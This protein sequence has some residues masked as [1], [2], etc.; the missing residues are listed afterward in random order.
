MQQPFKSN[1]TAPVPS[2]DLP[3]DR[4]H[5]YLTKFS[6]KIKLHTG[7]GSRLDYDFTSGVATAHKTLLA[8]IA[9]MTRIAAVAGLECEARDAAEG[10]FKAFAE[11]RAKQEAT[12]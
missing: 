2:S 1:L 12:A 3:P 8:V 6:A 7:T 10:S 5:D 11:W 9:E 4:P